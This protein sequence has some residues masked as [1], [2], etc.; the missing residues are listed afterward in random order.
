MCRIGSSRESGVKTKGWKCVLAK[1]IKS[2][3]VTL[4]LGTGFCTTCGHGGERTTGLFVTLATQKPFY[5]SR[6][7]FNLA[8]STNLERTRFKAKLTNL[9]LRRCTCYFF[10]ALFLFLCSHSSSHSCCSK[11]F[12]ATLK[13]GRILG[14]ALLSISFAA[15]GR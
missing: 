3:R 11:I 7:F 12:Q 4:C 15:A 13:H 5:P 8:L 14:A 1:L 9:C 2:K 6:A 10:I